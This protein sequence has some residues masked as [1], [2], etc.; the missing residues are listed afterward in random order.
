M[1]SGNGFGRTMRDQDRGCSHTGGEA[2]GDGVSCA[3]K[4]LCAIVRVNGSAT[5]VNG[6]VRGFR[7][8]DGDGAKHASGRRSHAGEGE[9][10]SFP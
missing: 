2:D 8:A 9:S 7:S 5:S 6:G 3:H 4:S 10:V 1:N